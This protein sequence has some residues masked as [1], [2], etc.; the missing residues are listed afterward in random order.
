V[1]HS[2]IRKEF[3]GKFESHLIGCDVLGDVGELSVVAFALL[4]IGAEATNT[5]LDII[6]EF[7]GVDLL[8]IDIA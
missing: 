2:S 3:F 4:D 5:D 1:D 8:G 7:H 6:R